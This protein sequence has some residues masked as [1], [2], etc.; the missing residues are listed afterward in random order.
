MII[1]IKQSHT[2]YSLLT[3]LDLCKKNY[4]TLLITYLARHAWREKRSDENVSLLDLKMI[5]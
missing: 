4:Q 1:I 3:L 2:K 5:D